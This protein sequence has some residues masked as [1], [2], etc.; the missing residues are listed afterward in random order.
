MCDAARALF[1]CFFLF[2]C[3]SADLWVGE[4]GTGGEMGVMGCTQTNTQTTCLQGHAGSAPIS[5]H[6]PRL[7]L[8]STSDL[9]CG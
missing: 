7:L 3:F 5:L 2:F 6:I 1:S 4:G 8:H 9:K